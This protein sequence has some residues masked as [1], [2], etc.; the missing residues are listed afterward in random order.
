VPRGVQVRTKN[1]GL[2]NHG[3]LPG[4]GPGRPK[5]VPNKFNGQLKE[6]LL[7][8]FNG[9][10]PDGL[11]SWVLQEA[12]ANPTAAWRF[13]GGSSPSRRKAH[14]TPLL[15][16]VMSMKPRIKRSWCSRAGGLSSLWHCSG[17]GSGFGGQ[18]LPGEALGDRSSDFASA[19]ASP[20]SRPTYMDMPWHLSVA[21]SRSDPPAGFILPCRPT[22][23]ASPPTGPG[24]LHEM[25]HDGLRILVRKQGERV[26]V[27]SRRGALFNDRFPSIAEAVGA[28]PVDTAL[29]DGEAVTF[30]PDGHSDFAA[31]RTK[32][33]GERASFVAFDLLGLEDDDLRERPLEQRRDAL[34]RLVHGAD[35]VRFSEALAAEGAIVF[36]HACKLGLEGIVSKRAGSRYRSGTSRNW[37]KVLNPKFERRDEGWR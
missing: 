25:K 22:L 29:I 34:A 10:H 23:V 15:S 5:G 9:A 30:L 28:L 6:A 19:L 26:E 24:W 32:E 33:G 31:L 36:A 7:S 4:P 13:W 2:G 14:W 20:S 8:A 18:K 3:N 37:L 35:G 11:A 12:K 27:W 17:M 21:R 1:H 16:F